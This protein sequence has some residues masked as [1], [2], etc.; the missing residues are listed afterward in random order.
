MPDFIQAQPQPYY[1]DLESPTPIRLGQGAQSAL[2]I[3]ALPSPLDLGK[4]GQNA[5]ALLQKKNEAVDVEIRAKELERAVQS[6][7]LTEGIHA[8]QKELQ[9]KLKAGPETEKIPDQVKFTP[10]DIQQTMGGLLAL[11][12]L[13]GLASRQPLTAS[14]NAMAGMIQGVREGDETRFQRSFKEYD[15]NLKTVLAK[16]K[17][18]ENEFNRIVKSEELSITQKAEE[19]RL[20]NVQFDRQVA[21][22]AGQKVDYK[23]MLDLGMKSIRATTDAEL[24]LESMKARAQAAAL[25]SSDRRYAAELASADR[26]EGMRLRYGG[27]SA[28]A[29]G[30]D[31]T[32]ADM[33]AAWS[34]LLNG[35]APSG[36]YSYDK[37]GR[38]R[39]NAAYNQILTDHNIDPMTAAMLPNANA[40][41]K[42]A[43]NQMTQRDSAI[44]VTQ[45][46]LI[47]HGEKLQE[48]VA[49][50]GGDTKSVHW[51]QLEVWA[52]Q[53]L[54]DVDAIE[55]K[56]QMVLFGNEFARLSSPTS[57]A[58]LP[59]G[60]RAES[61]EVLNTGYDKEAVAG[62]IDLIRYDAKIS[63]DAFTN[64]RK[65]LLTSM[66]D[67]IG[68]ANPAAGNKPAGAPDTAKQAPDG[69]WYSPDPTR[70]G[71]YILHE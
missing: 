66:T 38:A 37:A 48:L 7:P 18:Y 53:H 42:T 28:G 56:N 23:N 69:K 62:V 25:A 26:R 22:V 47:G 57:N 15:Q 70:P 10:T 19:L 14:L 6:K 44:R 71:K 34:L 55:L 1:S 58:M 49:K 29:A 4:S 46:K 64:E 41:I 51:N 9:Q 5:P 59:E 40:S 30:G 2:G 20:L 32:S 21:R 3:G 61:R 31:V 36:Q 33:A 12:A 67:G 35:K 50:G 39:M 60:A 11:A 43:L 65:R 52:K 54:N 16:N 24:K 45:E 68:A 17:Q 8:S 27:G 13:S 63:H